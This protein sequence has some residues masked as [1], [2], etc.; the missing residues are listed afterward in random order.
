MKK[1]CFYF[2]IL[3]ILLFAITGIARSESEITKEVTINFLNK[4]LNYQFRKNSSRCG[5]SGGYYGYKQK[6]D[7]IG[8]SLSS[9]IVKINGDSG[10]SSKHATWSSDEA[11]WKRSCEIELQNV[12]SVVKSET[13]ECG[14]KIVVVKL[15]LNKKVQRKGFI[16]TEYDREVMLIAKEPDRVIKALKHLINLFGGKVIKGDDELFK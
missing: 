16:P 13:R 6:V 2:N 10:G 12:M 5:I 4:Q 14:D 9:D 11:I 15:L 1:A 3:C 7:F 8:N